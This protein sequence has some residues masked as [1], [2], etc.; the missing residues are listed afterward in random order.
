MKDIPGAAL[1]ARE[2]DIDFM[3]C[4]I[5]QTDMNFGTSKRPYL[6]MLREGRA[7][8]LLPVPIEVKNRILENTAGKTENLEINLSIGDVITGKQ[9]LLCSDI[10]MSKVKVGTSNV[11]SGRHKRQYAK[12]RS[13]NRCFAFTV[14]TWSS[15]V[16]EPPEP[17]SYMNLLYS[18]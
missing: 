12:V 11:V 16:I 3:K 8:I 15:E 1:I 10:P 4:S 6:Y 14:V 13:E 17:M 9:I 18:L 5:K 7:E 2:I